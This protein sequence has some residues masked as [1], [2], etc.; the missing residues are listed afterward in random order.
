MRT[1]LSVGCIT[2]ALLPSALAQDSGIARPTVI[3]R[4]VVAGMPRGDRQEVR[5]IVASFKPG[6]KT[7]FHTHRSPVTVYVLEGAF[8]LEL[9]GREPV[10]V[11][12]GE[13]FVE[14][15]HVKMTG[16]NRSTTQTLKVVVFY[17]SDPDTPFLDVVH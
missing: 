3:H 4:E 14:P 5:V 15:A 13:A 9:E 1:L 17:V 8:T 11:K 7:V 12:T 2:A 6:D 10:T 16:Y